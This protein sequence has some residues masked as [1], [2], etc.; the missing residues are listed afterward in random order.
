MALEIFEL[1]K[2][3]LRSSLS[4]LRPAIQIKTTWGWSGS[5]APMYLRKSCWGLRVDTQ[6]SC[7]H[8]N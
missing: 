4:C 2:F 7:A 6:T 8:I 3:H 1:D 5:V